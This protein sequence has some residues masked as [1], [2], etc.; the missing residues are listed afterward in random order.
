ML[1]PTPRAVMAHTDP[2]LPRRDAD[3]ARA[4]AFL[5]LLGGVVIAELV[6]RPSAGAWPVSAIGAAYLVVAFILLWTE[7]KRDRTEK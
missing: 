7:G 5:L 1:D 4:V 6:A 2:G 3:F